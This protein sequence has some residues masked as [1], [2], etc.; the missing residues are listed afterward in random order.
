MRTPVHWEYAKYC[1]SDP[2]ITYIK[3]PEIEGNFVVVPLTST[4]VGAKHSLHK[5]VC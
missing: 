2:I 1:V 5:D 3:E 4:W